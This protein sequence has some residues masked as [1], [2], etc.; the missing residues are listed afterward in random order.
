MVSSGLHVRVT[1]AEDFQPI[2]SSILGQESRKKEHDLPT[3]TSSVANASDLRESTP[4]GYSKRWAGALW[5]A[6]GCRYN[7]TNA[8]L[9]LPIGLGRTKKKITDWSCKKKATKGT[10]ETERDGVRAFDMEI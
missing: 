5:P 4:R 10:E 6:G 9:L 8:M 2:S 1:L 3:M 7:R